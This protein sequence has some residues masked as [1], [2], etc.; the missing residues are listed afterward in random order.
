MKATF[1]TK[2]T[3]A[4][5]IGTNRKEKHFYKQFTAINKDLNAVIE[6]RLYAT[7][8]THYCCMWLHDRKHNIHVSGGGKAGGYGYHRASAAAENAINAA[9]I[10]LS[11]HIDGCGGTTIT[12]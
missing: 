4:H 12:T 5:S 10:S 3:N 11:E 8:S 7:Q 1:N 9:G 2:N 6:L